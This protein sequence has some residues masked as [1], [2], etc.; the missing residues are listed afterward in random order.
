M[1]ATFARKPQRSIELGLEARTETMG[2][3]VRYFP[4]MLSAHN[5]LHLSIFH[6]RGTYVIGD[7]VPLL[8]IR[9]TTSSTAAADLGES[10]HCIHRCQEVSPASQHERDSSGNSRMLGVEGFHN[11]IDVQTCSVQQGPARVSS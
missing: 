2:L 5:P 9:D 6:C 1:L 7:V 3:F 10:I 4:S 8:S 11:A